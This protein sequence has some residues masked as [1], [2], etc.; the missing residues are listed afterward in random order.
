MYNFVK[1]GITGG[2]VQYTKRYVSASN[3]YVSDYDSTKESNYLM[4]LDVNNL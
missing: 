1:W 2:I 4:H 3:K